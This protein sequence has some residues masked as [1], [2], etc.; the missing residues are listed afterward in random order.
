MKDKFI[1]ELQQNG[2]FSI[3]SMYLA[4]IM[5]NRGRSDMT[6]WKLKVPLKIKIFM[7]YLKRGV[8]LT[9][10][11]LIRRNWKGDKKCVFCAHPET[12]QHLFFEC[13]FAKFIWSA[14]QITF[15]I[16]MPVSVLHL[17]SVWETAW[18]NV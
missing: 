11:N 1:W 3:K 6:I 2:S 16:H 15:N 7:W 5:D 17:L 4:L 13:H 8:V 14:V 12:I 9:K 10:D 18:A